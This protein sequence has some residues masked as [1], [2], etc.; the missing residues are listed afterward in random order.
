MKEEL[1]N[2]NFSKEF[3]AEELDSMRSK[4]T[5]LSFEQDIVKTEIFLILL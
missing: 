5:D 4:I 2:L 1:N 3:L